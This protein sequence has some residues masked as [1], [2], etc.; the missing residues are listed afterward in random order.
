MQDFETIFQIAADRKGGPAALAELLEFPKPSEQ[1]ASIP[2]DRWLSAMA[3]AIFQAGFNWKVV[4]NMWPGFEKAFDEFDIGRCSM[5]NDDDIDALVA[6][7]NII[8]HPTKI[9]S[10][11]QN[12]V[13]LRNLAS[14]HGSAG[15]FFANWPKQDFIGLLQL[16]KE[17]GSRLGGNTGPYFLRSMGVD[18]FILSRDVI[19]RLQAEGVIEG[20][21]SSRS[22]MKAIQ[23][24]FDHWSEQS[25]RSLS[26]ISRILAMSID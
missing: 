3:R 9:R 17:Q 22:A 23:N 25:G 2:D 4:E 8:R 14:S 11:Q 5:L 20:S 21:H 16:L 10:V 6:N 7:R 15:R 18:G 24:A 19:K 12:A 26:E 1:L 13:F